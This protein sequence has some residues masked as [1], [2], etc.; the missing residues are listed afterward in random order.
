[1]IAPQT[2]YLTS[3]DSFRQPLVTQ[4]QLGALQATTFSNVK[5]NSNR[6]LTSNG[7]TVNLEFGQ[8]RLSL[9]LAHYNIIRATISATQKSN[10]F[11][12]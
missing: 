1:M 8:R 2:G 7:S 4:L 3:R 5:I 10:Y 9:G 11:R 6:L 12:N